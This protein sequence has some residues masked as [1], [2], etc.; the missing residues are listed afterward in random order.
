MT[1]PA[2]TLIATEDGSLTL[3]DAARDIHYRSIHGAA[4]EARHVFID[5]ARL[6]ERVGP[7]RVLE[8][9]FGAATTFTQTL[10]ALLASPLA[11]SLRY[12]SVE[13]APV[14]CDDVAHLPEEAR[15]LACAVLEGAPVARSADGRVQLALHRCDWLN[16]DLG[17]ARF[18]AIYLDPFSPAIDPDA[19]SVRAMEVAVAHMA[20]DAI[21][22]TYG[23]SRAARRAM[24]AAGLHVAT[25][26][27]TG[28]KR[29]VTVAALDPARLSHA[30]ALDPVRLRP[31]VG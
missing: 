17:D 4:T 8:L 26:P 22:A 14:S 20:D 25:R 23:A 11:T 27:G 15:A 7:W 5:G 21:L 29:E 3:Y 1:R 30:T 31:H 18:D 2:L 19:W 6:P 24:I 16:L 12:D 28:R 9:G 13:R 10:A